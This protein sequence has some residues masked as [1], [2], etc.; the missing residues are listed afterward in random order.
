MS[1]PDVIVVGAGLAGLSAALGLLDRGVEPLVLEAQPRVGGRTRGVELAPGVCVDGGATYFGVK[2]TALAALMERLGLAK[3]S[4]SMAGDSVFLF[5]GRRQRVPTRLPPLSEV[6]LGELFEALHGLAAFVNVDEP[7]CGPDAEA[8]DRMTAEEW[9][10]KKVQHPDGRQFFRPFLGQLMATEP[11]DVSA[12]HMGLYIKAG[13]GL[14]YLNAFEGG[15]QEWRIDGGAHRVCEGLAAMLAPRLRMG[16]PVRRVLCSAG[17]VSVETDRSQYSARAAIIAI[18]PLLGSALE[19]R[20]GPAQPSITHAVPGCVIK[21]HLVY[22]A[23]IWRQRGLSGWS[24]SSTGPLMSTVDDS[25]PGA[26]GVLTGFITG[27]DAREFST[28]SPAS[29]AREVEQQLRILFPE[30]PAP[31]GYHETDWI[32]AE[33]SRGCYAT[34]FG[35]GHWTARRETESATD[36]LV[37]CGTETSREFF[38]FMEGAVRS[39][40]RAARQVLARSSTGRAAHLHHDPN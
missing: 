3:S 10:R 25:P 13:G 35:P 38:G 12:L 27:R 32:A 6:G 4:I 7:G 18:P 29:R 19:V 22:P 20:P 34:V 23:P 40:Q 14:R 33:Y 31:D 1:T 37:W 17:G 16:E 21:V 30:L 15:A 36:D 24:V 8:L 39:G 26:L 9:L 5:S 2:H 28:Q 11:E